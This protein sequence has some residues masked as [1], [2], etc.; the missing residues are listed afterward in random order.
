MLKCQKIGSGEGW[1]EEC[2]CISVR[3]S[4]SVDSSGEVRE[5]GE[6]EIESVLIMV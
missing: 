1:G 6:N 4:P 5:N 2:K 3:K